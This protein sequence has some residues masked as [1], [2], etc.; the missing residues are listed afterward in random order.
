MFAAFKEQSY[1]TIVTL[2]Q[3]FIRHFKKYDDL[4][5]LL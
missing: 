5:M 4:L 2:S 3:I 1:K